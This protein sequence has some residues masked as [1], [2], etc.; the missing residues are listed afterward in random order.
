MLNRLSIGRRI[1][2]IVLV[3]IRYGF[4]GADVDENNYVKYEIAL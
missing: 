2:G 1:I 3:I 4:E